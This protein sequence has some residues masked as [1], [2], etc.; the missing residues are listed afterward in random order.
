M[1][2]KI[3]LYYGEDVL[4]ISVFPS[5]F[6]IDFPIPLTITALKIEELKKEETPQ[7]PEYRFMHLSEESIG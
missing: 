5:C 1:D 6:F 7:D 3:T 4:F 2:K